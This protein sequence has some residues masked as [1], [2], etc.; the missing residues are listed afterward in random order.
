MTLT[1]NL[2]KYRDYMIAIFKNEFNFFH[3]LIEILD[4]LKR[5]KIFLEI[6]DNI[7]RDE[8]KK[9][10]FYTNPDIELEELLTQ[11]QISFFQKY[12]LNQVR[13]GKEVYVQFFSKLLKF[14]LSYDNF[15]SNNKVESEE[16]QA[17]K[18]SIAQSLIRM[19]F[20]RD[21]K[22]YIKEKFYEYNLIKKIIDKDIEET[23]EKY[24]DQY[25]T[26]FR[27]EDICDDFLK[28]MFF[29]FG[30]KMM[31]ESFVNP[32]KKLL[33]EIGPKD[34]DINKD[35]FNNLITDF[36]SKLKENIPNVLKLLLKILYESIRSHFTIEIDNY[37]PLYTTLIFNFINS[38]RVQTLYDINSLNSN[39]IRSLNRLLR[40]ACFN[41][42]FSDQD[43]LNE[44]NDII[45]KNH[46]KIKNFIKKNI[47]E[48]NINDGKVKSSLGD[49][50]NEKYL[51]YPNFLFHLDKTILLD[52]MKG[53]LNDKDKGHIIEK[54]LK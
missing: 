13:Y 32:V 2:D 19:I 20:S 16:K 27:K 46:L 33:T 45:E 12:C 6:I 3:N 48:I 21:K 26:L 51:I 1:L 22:K 50:F 28:Y 49:I 11:E 30:N 42:K 9:C 44:F 8:Y 7:F 29:V 41:F 52:C 34:R 38:P 10:F 18:L 31:I 23:R 37:G 25:K 17:Y 40:N 43:P 54:V 14:D 15:F 24:G 35:E 36:I 53:E 47:I 4:P 39:L 5:N